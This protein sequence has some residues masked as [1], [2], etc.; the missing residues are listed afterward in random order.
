M[1]SL[2]VVELIYGFSGEGGVDLR[3]L[4]LDQ[5]GEHCDSQAYTAKSA[6]PN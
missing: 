5:K 2:E 4:W 3:F 6:N 1:I